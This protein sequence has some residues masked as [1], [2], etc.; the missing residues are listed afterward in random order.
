MSPAPVRPLPIGTRVRVLH[1]SRYGET[2]IVV[3]GR[4]EPRPG[5]AYVEFRDHLPSA[6]VLMAVASL[7]VARS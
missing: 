7:E 4:P 5:Y 2:G 3:R 1:G 6:S